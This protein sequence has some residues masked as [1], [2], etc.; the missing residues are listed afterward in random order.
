LAGSDSAN[1]RG[2]AFVGLAAMLTM[3]AL[4]V[5][6]VML[7][8]YEADITRA[9]AGTERVS[10]VVASKDILVGTTLTKDL[11]QVWEISPEYLPTYT[12]DNQLR[13]AETF[14]A[15]EQLIGHAAKEPIYRNEIV[16]TERLTNRFLGEGLHALIADG[17]RA[18]ALELKG[19]QA[20]KGFLQPGN[21]V[22]ILVSYSTEG[23]PYTE[24]L[25][26]SVRVLA[27]NEVAS[28][29]E[30]GEVWEEGRRGHP[31]VIFLVTPEQA[32]DLAYADETGEISLSLR[33]DSDNNSLQLEGS[34]LNELLG[35]R[36]PTRKPVKV[37]KPAKEQF[38]SFTIIRSGN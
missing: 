1:T 23:R 18:F 10:V 34:N 14:T 36:P 26:Q 32:R 16:R 6:F 3:G 38:G 17:H 35:R 2:L 20:I 19:S 8:K 7:N 11:L 29:E 25:L 24:T 27:V 13:L 9:S 15:V 12:E 33:N 21:V 30:D 4:T 28:V 22:D 31:T 37:A 5:L